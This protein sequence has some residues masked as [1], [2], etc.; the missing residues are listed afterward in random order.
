M[1]KKIKEIQKKIKIL[2]HSPIINPAILSVDNKIIHTDNINS[3]YKIN[4]QV[5]KI[6]SHT[7]DKCDIF[8]FV[9]NM[10]TKKE[11]CD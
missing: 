11:I 3:F 2:K 9:K 1:N 6:D 10:K 4:C 5:G 8:D 7:Y